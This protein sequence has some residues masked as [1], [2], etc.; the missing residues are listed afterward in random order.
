MVRRGL[1]MIK[2]VV[3]NLQIFIAFTFVAVSSWADP[4]E[5]FIKLSPAGSYVMKSSAIEGV[6]IS[7][8]GKVKAASIK[9]PVKSLTTGIS[10]RDKHTYERL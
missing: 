5:V 9:V 8:A 1:D 7:G 3:L 4:V 6:V 10:L 2:R